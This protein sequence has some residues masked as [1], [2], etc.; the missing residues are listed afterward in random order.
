MPTASEHPKQRIGLVLDLNSSKKASTKI[1][2]PPDAI[3]QASLLI[4]KI[5]LTQIHLILRASI[6]ILNLLFEHRVEHKLENLTNGKY[7]FE[8]AGVCHLVLE[9]HEGQ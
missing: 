5:I 6:K 1:I 7:E 3:Q 8:I 9:W 4:H 2:Q